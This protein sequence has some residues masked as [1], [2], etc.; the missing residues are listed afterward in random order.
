MVLLCITAMTACSA[1][2]G[3]ATLDDA[4]QRLSADAGDLLRT[5]GLGPPV[6]EEIDDDSCLPG[7]AR[8]FLRTGG[9]LPSGDL[10][11]TLRKLGYDQIVDDLDLRDED[12]DVAVL[13]NPETRL[14][15]ELTVSPGE[16]PGVRILG[17][18]TCYA[19]G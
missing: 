2:T 9:D 10:L 8:R 15:F 5:T 18:T 4:T 13:R 1:A 17:K 16:R 6:V 14:T 11:D 12:P 19:S 3:P 7:Q